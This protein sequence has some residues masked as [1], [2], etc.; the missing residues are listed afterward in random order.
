MHSFDKVQN[1]RAV[2]SPREVLLK[3]QQ[4]STLPG[5]RVSIRRQEMMVNLVTI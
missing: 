5:K 2:N 4:G 3:M 1:G